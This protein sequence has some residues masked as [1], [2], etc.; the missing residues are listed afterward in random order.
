MSG[1]DKIGTLVNRESSVICKFGAV[2]ILVEVGAGGLVETSCSRLR[3]AE[4]N[5][6]HTVHA[7]LLYSSEGAGEYVLCN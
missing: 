3:G 2:K 4:E 1:V 7:V 6:R 5:W